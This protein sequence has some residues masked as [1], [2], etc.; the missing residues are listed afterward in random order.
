[1]GLFDPPDL[2]VGLVFKL[3]HSLGSSE[4]VRSTMHVQ[5]AHVVS[6]WAAFMINNPSSI[7]I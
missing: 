1:M 7:S 3:K 6:V 2:L 5:L 4:W